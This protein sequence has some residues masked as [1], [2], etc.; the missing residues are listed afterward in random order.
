MSVIHRFLRSMTVVGMILWFI[1]I[2][3][4]EAVP[5][6]NWQLTL[7]IGIAAILVFVWYVMHESD[8]DLGFY[9][10]IVAGTC[11][12]VWIIAAILVGAIGKSAWFW[13]TM[14]TATVLGIVGSIIWTD[15]EPLLVVDENGHILYSTRLDS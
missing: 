2:M 8:D 11:V 14:T 13:P 9:N 7:G 10:F 3:R 1:F 4:R 15:P 12:V 5:L 6:I